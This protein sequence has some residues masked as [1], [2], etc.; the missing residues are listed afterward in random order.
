MATKSTTTKKD[1]TKKSSSSTTKKKS[2]SSSKKSSS[3]VKIPTTTKQAEKLVKKAAKKNPV[4]FIIIIIVLIALAAGVF[5]FLYFGGYIGPKKFTGLRLIGEKTICLDIG[6]TYEEKGVELVIKDKVI[7]TT[8]YVVTTTYTQNGA[9]VSGIV[10]TDNT[11]YV[12]TYE[13]SYQNANYSV[14]RNVCVGVEPISINLIAPGNKYNGD[15]IYIKAG[16]TD[17]LIDAGSRN[18]SSSAIYDYITQPGRCEDGKLEYVIA[19][20]AHQDHIAGF[21]GTKDAPSIFDRLEVGTLIQFAQSDATSQL[22]SQYK[23]KVNTLKT[24]KGTTVVT[25]LD[26]WKEQNGGHKEYTIAN[27]TTMEILYQK[28]Y[29]EK[30]PGKNEN[31]YSVALMINHGA[32]H[33]LLTGDLEEEGEESLVASNI[34]P[35]VQFFKAN[36]H[37]SYTANSDELLSV[38]KPKTIG[39]CCT[40]G[41]EEFTSDLN[42][43]FPAQATISTIGKYTDKIY[44]TQVVDGDSYKAFNGNIEFKSMSGTTY[45]VHGSASDT[46]LK[47]CQWIKDH[48]TWPSLLA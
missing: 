1:T 24:S 48:R 25:A 30:A 3:A 47:E 4:A 46:I 26:C 17:I 29:E 35:E 15:S 45:E 5:A 31:L 20:H 16:E 33:Y 10:T 8:E 12:V 44:A 2:T 42:N 36:H 21:V 6:G 40:V 34:L 39:I 7:P 22:Y 19:T 37:G 43:V 18:S 41:L 9:T 27:G 28:Y 11:N 38:I 14:K 23:E 13:T 32:N